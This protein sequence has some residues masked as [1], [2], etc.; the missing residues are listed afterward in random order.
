MTS[1]LTEVDGCAL[2]TGAMTM[3]T[4]K[5]LQQAGLLSLSRSVTLF[6]LAAVTDVDS[7]SLAVIFAWLRQAKE[8]ALTITLRNP[9]ESL[10]SLAEVY[11]VREML[12]LVAVAV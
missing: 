5:A 6:D 12:P 1:D 11:G 8:N 10:L 3:D 4:A 2:I 9:P 7:S